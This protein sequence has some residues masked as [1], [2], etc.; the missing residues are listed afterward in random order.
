MKTQAL[1]WLMGWPRRGVRDL[2]AVI[3]KH[4]PNSYTPHSSL[5]AFRGKTLA[6]DAN[7]L[8]IKFHHRK[9]KHS[10]PHSL[11]PSPSA[12]ATAAVASAADPAA[13][14]G[15]GDPH[16]HVKAWYDF[17]AEL[18]ALD[19]KPI[20]VFDGTTRVPEKALENERRR[21]GRELQVNRGLAE[22]VRSA[23]LREV[24]HLWD[25]LGVGERWQVARDF[26]Q[27]VEQAKVGD[28]DTT[29]DPATVAG[30]ETQPTTITPTPKPPIP[31]SKSTKPSSNP[32]EQ[33]ADLY[34]SLQEDT[35]NPIYSKN[36]L[37]I[38]ESESLF[39][40]DLFS[41]GRF[42]LKPDFGTTPVADQIEVPPATEAATDEGTEDAAE[43]LPPV[44]DVMHED[45]EEMDLGLS[46]MLRESERLGASHIARGEG[47]PKQAFADSLVSVSLPELAV[48]TAH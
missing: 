11:P 5:A 44:I 16:R 28:W 14:P 32:A 41:I 46:E 23:R 31:P 34:V 4:A 2:G 3:L 6:L 9:P 35:S 43:R 29:A 38:S 30:E 15:S 10:W 13:F 22:A 26:V 24:K 1:M 7:L 42:P 20:V 18:R 25:T 27:L 48:G 40:A 45:A 39:F 33:F 37:A 21:A 12:T 17:L 36:Q 8:T 19:I 47:V